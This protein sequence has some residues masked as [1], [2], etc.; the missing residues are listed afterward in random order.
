MTQSKQWHWIPTNL[1]EEEFEEFVFPHLVIGSRGPLPKL[2]LY[3]IFNYILK[4]L[5]I[6]CQ[7]TPCGASRAHQFSQDAMPLSTLA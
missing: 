7:S 3:A 5:H 2:S 4:L 6:G 1:S